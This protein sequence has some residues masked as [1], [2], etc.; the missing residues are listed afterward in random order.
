MIFARYDSKNPKEDC[1][2]VVGIKKQCKIK[3]CIVGRDMT[4]YTE[5]CTHMTGEV[6][7]ID[8]SFSHILIQTE[9]GFYTF[10]KEDGDEDWRERINASV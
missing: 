1:S 9:H 3:T 5:N 8:E 10:E 7:S 2:N 4:F 6:I